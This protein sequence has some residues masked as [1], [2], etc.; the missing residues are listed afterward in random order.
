MRT[1][2][3]SPDTVG[4]SDS[5]TDDR[6][7]P[8]GRVAASIWR[9]DRD[10]ERCVDMTASSK[11][12]HAPREL[13]RFSMDSS[14]ESPAVQTEQSVSSEAFAWGIAG[15]GQQ[16]AWRLEASSILSLRITRLP[17]FLTR[18]KPYAVQRPITMRVRQLIFW[19]HR[20]A[21]PVRSDCLK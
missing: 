9:S 2:P 19:V 18:P 20:S 14:A 21:T 7:D 15:L 6:R 17:P 13:K 8:T 10:A 4:G 1:G 3:P 12:L 16:S 11:Q 5:D